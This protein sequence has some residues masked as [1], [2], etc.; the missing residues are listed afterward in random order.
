M[1]WRTCRCFSAVGLAACPADAAAEVKDAAHFVARAAGGRGAVR[2]VVEVILKSQGRWVELISAAAATSIIAEPE[3]RLPQGA[4]RLARRIILVASH[5]LSEADS[6]SC[7]RSSSNPWLPF[8]S[9]WDVTSG[10]SAFA[11]VVQQFNATQHRRHH[12]TSRTRSR[13][14]DRSCTPGL[15]SAWSL[16]LR[17]RSLL[18]LLQLR[19]RVLD[20]RPEAKKTRLEDGVHYDGKRMRLKPFA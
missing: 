14:R 2:E 17:Q 16:G 7:S 20:V 5:I 6:L 1:T 9:S 10:T 13:R 19:A 8:P 3:L 18:S 15:P 11:I 4:R 12:V